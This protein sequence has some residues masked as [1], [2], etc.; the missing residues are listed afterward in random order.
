MSSVGG[1]LYFLQKILF[2]VRTTTLQAVWCCQRKKR[3]QMINAERTHTRLP[4]PEEQ[5][6]RP[7]ARAGSRSCH[8]KGAV[9][10]RMPCLSRQGM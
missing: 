10:R 3:A 5:H 9:R 6:D 1:L 2:I 4:A 7:E 8:I